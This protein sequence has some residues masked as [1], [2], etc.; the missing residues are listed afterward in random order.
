M[1]TSLHFWKMSGAGNDFVVV[2][3]RAGLP[4]PAGELAAQ[5]C[6][7]RVGIGADGLLA[8]Q[9]VSERRVV[10]DYRNAD[11]SAAD[12]CGNGARCVARFAYVREIAGSPMVLAFPGQEVRATVEG[13]RVRI[14][15]PRPRILGRVELVAADGSRFEAVQVDA[16]VAHLV[17]HVADG[18]AP[19]LATLRAALAR[20]RP[21][22]LDRVN[23]TTVERRGADALHVRTLE[24]GS[25][26]TLA[27]GSG[28]LAATALEPRAAAGVRR[29]V[30]PPAGIPLVVRLA[31]DPGPASLEG[32]AV[33]VFHGVCDDVGE[34]AP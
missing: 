17:V 32:D 27:C 16:G 30:I 5:L 29:V 23:L 9:G 26:E 7:R 15:T 3:A 18:P 28:A 1:T 6:R 4:A 25:G 24:R 34:P 21:D 20:A 11:G 31:P 14:E 10:V 2:D 19:P 12:F 22:L 13:A 33:I 8:V